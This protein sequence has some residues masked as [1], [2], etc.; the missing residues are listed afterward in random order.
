MRGDNDDWLMQGEGIFACK[1][2]PRTQ[3]EKMRQANSKRSTS[4]RREK[5]WVPHLPLSLGCT[6]DC[7]PGAYGPAPLDAGHDKVCFGVDTDF[8]GID[9]MESKFIGQRRKMNKRGGQRGVQTMGKEVQ[10]YCEDMCQRTFNVPI[11]M[12]INDK[13]GG[14]GMSVVGVYEV[15]RYVRS[16]QIIDSTVSIH[17]QAVNAQK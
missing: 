17:C 7:A 13:M 1:K 8:Y 4:T 10:G 15:G 14:W 16:L 9:E 5:R 3:E 2:F 12:K 11:D 6:V